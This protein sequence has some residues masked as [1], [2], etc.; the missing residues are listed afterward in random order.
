MTNQTTPANGRS[1]QP[2]YPSG[3]AVESS[4]QDASPE[5]LPSRNSGKENKNSRA[6]EIKK[7]CN[8]SLPEG[9]KV[10]ESNETSIRSVASLDAVGAASG[11]GRG[12]IGG[13]RKEKTIPA[14]VGAG[15]DRCACAPA[16]IGDSDA[17]SGTPQTDLPP[18][19]RRASDVGGRRP[20]RRRAPTVRNDR[21]RDEGSAV[22]DWAGAM[23]CRITSKSLYRFI[24][25]IAIASQSSVRVKNLKGGDFGVS[26]AYDDAAEGGA[27]VRMAN[28]AGILSVDLV[29]GHAVFTVP[30]RLCDLETQVRFERAAHGKWV[31]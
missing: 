15:S 12:D 22:S 27:V 18:W 25:R 6:G 31:V 21:G 17:T 7:N 4:T 23:S 28:A 9:G 13:A 8:D 19:G 14:P 26:V 30:R 1:Y 2:R 16:R 29:L 10:S 20:T 3:E 11:A 5:G 24:S